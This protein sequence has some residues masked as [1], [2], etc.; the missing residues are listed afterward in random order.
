MQLRADERTVLR[1]PVEAD[2]APMFA[3][4]GRDRAHLR[5]WLGWVDG[6]REA[7]D[8][9]AFIRGV[10]SREI[11]GT[12]LELV[13][14]HGGELAGVSGFR[15]LEAANRCGEIGYWL[16]EDFGGRGIMTSCCRALLRH[17]FESLGL[18]RIAVAAA[19]ENRRSRAV[20]ERLGFQL[21][22]VRRDGEWLYDHFVDLAVYSL[23]RRDPQPP[24]A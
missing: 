21:E 6:V 20:A 18:N 19:V 16:R 23:L 3:L 7:A 5:R 11:E 4:I 8:I 2:A 10:Q 13:I 22:G 24:R 1:S 15:S 14:E 12:S 9:A 17:G